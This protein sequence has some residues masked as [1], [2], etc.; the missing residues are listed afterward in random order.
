MAGVNMKPIDAVELHKLISSAAPGTDITVGNQFDVATVVLQFPPNVSDEAKSRAEAILSGYDPNK[1]TA[2]EV[3][4]E[5]SRRLQRMFGAR[6]ETHLN[7]MIA[8]ATREAVRLQ[9]IRLA[10]GS[11]TT[12]QATRAAQLVAADEAVEAIRAASNAMEPNP[13]A[14]YTTDSHWPAT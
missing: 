12:E 10:G 2:N 7:I 6:D 9:N 8:N 3:R 14:D 1:T 4:A 5:A 13:P 11:W